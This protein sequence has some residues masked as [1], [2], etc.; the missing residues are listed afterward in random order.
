MVAGRVAESE[1][2]G[3]SGILKNDHRKSRLDPIV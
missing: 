2:F 3:R 1:V